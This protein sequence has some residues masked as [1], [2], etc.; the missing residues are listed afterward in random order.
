M[1]DTKRNV[2]SF[3]DSQGLSK[4]LDLSNEAQQF[5]EFQASVELKDVKFKSLNRING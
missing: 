1:T 2:M 5:P 4:I 3:I